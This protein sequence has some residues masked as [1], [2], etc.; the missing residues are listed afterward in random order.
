VWG[1]GNDGSVEYATR[2]AVR[3][4]LRRLGHDAQFSED[5]AAE[6]SALRD[7]IDDETLQADAAHLIFVLYGAR[8]T[9]TE[10]DMILTLP[11]IAAKSV[12]FIE[13]SLYEIVKTKSLAGTS[14]ETA[15]R[16]S[17][18]ITYRSGDLPAAL[19]SQASTIAHEFRVAYYVRALRHRER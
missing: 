12:I 17:R 13:E 8:G 9:Q 3:D 16:A 19:V 2:C 7:P 4:E 6:P 18:I 15:N 11:G 14:W 10:R 5:L 1:P